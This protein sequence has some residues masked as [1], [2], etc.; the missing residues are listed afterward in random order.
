MYCCCV[1]LV[2]GM[3]VPEW[4]CMPPSSRFLTKG[5]SQNGIGAGKLPASTRRPVFRICVASRYEDLPLT[6]RAFASTSAVPNFSLPRACALACGCDCPTLFVLPTLWNTSE[7]APRR[8]ASR[9]VR[10]FLLPKSEQ[11]DPKHFEAFPRRDPQNR[12]SATP[13]PSSASDLV[14]D[15]PLTYP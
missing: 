10:F 9:M 8:T 2:L 1:S 7:R 14:H 13:I 11:S 15:H 5:P 4:G 12:L 6:V 3:H